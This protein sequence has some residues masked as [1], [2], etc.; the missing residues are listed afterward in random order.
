MK[1]KR[2]MVAM[3]PFYQQ[4]YLVLCANKYT[5]TLWD[6]ANNCENTYYAG[7]SYPASLILVSEVLCEI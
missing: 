5:L 6:L 4:K 3:E 1:F 2:G 7:S